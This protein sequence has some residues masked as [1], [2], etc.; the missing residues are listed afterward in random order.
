MGCAIYLHGTPSTLGRNTMRTSEAIRL[1]DSQC[2]YVGILRKHRDDWAKFNTWQ[3]ETEIKLERIFGPGNRHFKT[4]K[5]INYSSAVTLIGSGRDIAGEIRYWN[6]GLDEAQEFFRLMK[7]EIKSRSFFG[8]IS[9]P[10]S[11]IGTISDDKITIRWIMA[12]LPV[13][14]IVIGIAALL[15]VFLAGVRVGQIPFVNEILNALFKE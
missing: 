6:Q 10:K 3:R 4:F 15:T 12:H 7:D 11:E 13:A 8:F 9:L 14:Y 1:L 5:G 2:Q